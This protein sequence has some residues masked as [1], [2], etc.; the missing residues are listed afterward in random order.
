VPA[1]QIQG[2]RHSLTKEQLTMIIGEIEI[3]INIGARYNIAP[4]QIVPAIWR[5]ARGIESVDMQWGFKSPWSKQPLI[6][7][8]A[9]TV[10]N[11]MFR[12]YLPQRCLIPA[13]GFYE[14]TADKTP[15]RFTMPRDEPFCFA[16]LWQE[17]T[18]HEMDVDTKEYRCVILTT[19]PNASVGRVHNRM[20]LIVQPR[21]Y[22]WWLNETGLFESVLNNPC[23]DEMHYCPVSRALNNVRN[24]EPELIRPAPVQKDLL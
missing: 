3:I 6:N 12:Q 7:A 24:E 18:K 22:D 19:T 21:H 14:W 8:K 11:T 2:R 5:S 16:G 9:E 10:S 15:I 4:T 1:T 23:R 13:D 17:E 20:P